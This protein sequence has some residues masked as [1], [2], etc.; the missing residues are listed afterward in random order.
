[1]K[2]LGRKRIR[3]ATLVVAVASLLG[4]GVA[5]AYGADDPPT[6]EPHII[7]GGEASE[8]YPFMATLGFIDGSGTDTG[9]QCG[10]SLVF[11]DWVLTAGHC[12]K[13]PPTGLT[14][15]EQDEL[16]AQFGMDLYDH[17]PSEGTFYVKV[18]SHDR[19]AGVTANVTQIV[20]HEDFNWFEGS[21]PA[22]A[23]D[24][25]MAKLDHEL[26]LQPIQL[27]GDAADPEAAIRL[28]GWGITAPDTTG[29]DPIT[30]QELDTT[31]AHDAECRFGIP[32]DITDGEI[33]TDNPHDTDGP[34]YGDS[35]GPAIEKGSDGRW[36]L[37]GTTSRGGRWCGTTTAIYTSPPDFRTW[38]YN[39]ARGVEVSTQPVIPEQRKPETTYT[40]PYEPPNGGTTSGALSQERD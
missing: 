20:V 31:V 19:R 10:A 37:V 26:D 24:I 36:K 4:V 32:G 1:M 11:R 2:F 5:T 12:L 8:P 25:A 34:C 29:T 21:P 30:L 22:K 17:V 7:G 33:C 28:L 27:A 39:T 40:L 23:N 15:E 13:D 14:A 38:I 18:G 3:L 6:V 9:H 16:S 35:G